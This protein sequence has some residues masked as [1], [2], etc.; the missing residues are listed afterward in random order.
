MSR[1]TLLTAAF[2]IGAALAAPASACRLTADYKTQDSD[3]VF[4]GEAIGVEIFNPEPGDETL[5]S[6]VVTFK[7]D[8][9]I[10]GEYSGDKLDVRFYPSAIHKAPIDLTPLRSGKDSLSVV[11]VQLD[12]EMAGQSRIIG[13]LC[14]EQYYAVKP[15]ADSPDYAKSSWKNMTQPY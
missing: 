13:G 6:T 3:V 15:K 12:E 8:H 9:M 1:L 11:G 5:S 14:T 4:V 2:V 10:R 7:I